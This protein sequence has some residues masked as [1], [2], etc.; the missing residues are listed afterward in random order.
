MGCYL[1]GVWESTNYVAKNLTMVIK[2]S[3]NKRFT[4]HMGVGFFG[5]WFFVVVVV[6]LF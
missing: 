5:V 1:D 3:L 4:L 2:M 6:G